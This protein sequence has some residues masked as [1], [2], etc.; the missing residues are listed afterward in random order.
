MRKTGSILT[1]WKLYS[2]VMWAS[3]LFAS[4]LDVIAGESKVFLGKYCI[5]TEENNQI[6]IALYGLNDSSFLLPSTRFILSGSFA[7]FLGLG[8]HSWI[9]VGL[10]PPSHLLQE[11]WEMH[12]ESQVRRGSHLDGFLTQGLS[13]TL[14]A[15][16]S[17]AIMSPGVRL[18]WHRC[19]SRGKQLDM[20]TW[21]GFEIKCQRPKEELVFL[22]C[23]CFPE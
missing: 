18:L 15:A 21:K 16:S 23:E 19:S 22:V 8:L 10:W 20:W 9:I 11:C 17:G 2:E 7:F 4:S 3:Q 12:R 13:W 1:G 6:R 14:M 5:L